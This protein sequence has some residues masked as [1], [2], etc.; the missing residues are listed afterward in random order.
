M[1][2]ELL[3]AKEHI[4]EHFTHDASV[5]PM[6]FYPNWTRQFTRLKNWLDKSK[7]YQEMLSHADMPEIKSRI[8]NEGALS[9]KAFGTKTKDNKKM[10]YRPPHKLALDYMWYA[11]ELATSHREKFGK[12]YDLA[13]RVI[14][15][16]LRTQNINDADQI[17][18]LC[19]SAIERLSFGNSKDIQKFWDATTLKEVQ[20]WAQGTKLTQIEWQSI[21]GEWNKAYAPLD[22]EHR[23]EKISNPTSRL[24]I[25]NPFDPAIRDRI[26]LKK[27][28]A[29]DYKIEIFVPAAKRQWGYYVYPLLEGDKFIGRIE[30]KADRKKGHLNVI[31]FWQESDVKWNDTRRKKLG[32]ELE[33]MAK[34]VGLTQIN[35]TA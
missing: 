26:R 20:R 1:L 16:H 27:L 4:F 6:D 9:T 5:I 23:L 15:D 17:N 25:I 12:Y 34:F 22:I 13:H 7:R 32:E 30:L 14:P 11:G 28:F 24:R 10:W 19:S 8:E 21:D 2:D 29:F 31:N 33:R 18:W 3:S 35:W